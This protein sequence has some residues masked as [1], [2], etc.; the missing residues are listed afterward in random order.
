[1][2]AKPID[3][4]RNAIQPVIGLMSGTSADGIDAAILRTDGT[5]FMRTGIAASFAY[6]PALRASI[7][8]AMHDPVT[9][10]ADRAAHKTLSHAITD[11]H[12]AVVA[13]LVKQLPDDMQIPRLIGF[14]GQ[15]IFHEPDAN[16]TSPL[17]RCTI[18]LG[19]GQ[20]LADATAMDIVYDV[21]R[22]DMAAGGQGAP[23]APIYHAALIAAMDV[24][25][26]AVIINIGGVANLT[27]VG[28]KTQTDILGFDTGPGNAL[29]DDYMRAH[30]NQPFDDGGRIAAKGHINN[31]FVARVMRH[32]F[33]AKSWPKS[34][35]RHAFTHIVAD[36]G[37]HDL[38]PHDAMASLAALTV[39]GITHAVG[40]L[41]TDV[42]QIYIA[43]GGRRNQTLMDQLRVVFGDRLAI[44]ACAPFDAPFDA[45]L[46]EAELMAYLAARQRAG[47]PT[48]FPKTT[49]CK[50]PVCGGC[51]A[52]PLNQRV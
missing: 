41:P 31:D 17:G 3:E 7:F 1:M 37:L 20:R 38:A 4:D 2:Q 42:R 50:M 10:M 23:L 26:P 27:Y 52:Q 47:L 32:G 24:P 39:A 12:S 5:R 48:S 13:E 16:T 43:G 40:S 45:D 22:A 35:D 34:L 30:F 9:F 28:G 46:L 36:A 11:A 44:D 33:F 15:T 19:S 51:L 8:N 29:M 21:R 25:Y 18:Q 14:H 49:G 6:D